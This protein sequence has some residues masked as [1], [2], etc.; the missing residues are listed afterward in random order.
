MRAHIFSV[1]GCI[2]LV[3]FVSGGSAQTEPLALTQLTPDEFKWDVLSEACRALTR[4]PA[5]DRIPCTATPNEPPR[6]DWNEV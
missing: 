6:V 2:A 4:P 3:L 1:A 5:R